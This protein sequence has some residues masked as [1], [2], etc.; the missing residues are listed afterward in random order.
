MSD[1]RV[2]TAGVSF[3]DGAV[4]GVPEIAFRAEGLMKR[5]LLADQGIELGCK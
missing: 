4:D 1:Q 5:I 2:G 3:S